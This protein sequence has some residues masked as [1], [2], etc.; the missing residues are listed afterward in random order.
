MTDSAADTQAD[1]G[2]YEEIVACLSLE[3][4][5]SFFLY[6]GAGSGK[7]RLLVDALDHIGAIYSRRLELR[8]QK[9]GVITYTNAACDEILS[10]RNIGSSPL[11][12]VSTIHS[13]AWDLVRP[14]APD[15]R[16]WLRTDLAK[17]IEELQ[18]EEA[19]G[20]AGTQASITRNA[21]ISASHARLGYL[22][23]IKKF[24]YNPTGGNRERE[25]LNHSEVIE[26]CADLLKKPLMQSILVNRYPILLIDESQDTHGLLIDSL[27]GVEANHRGSWCF[28]LI[29][30]TMQRIYGDG[31]AGIE[32]VLPDVWAR[33]RKLLNY[34][35]PKRIVRLL[36]Q[37]RSEVDDHVQQAPENGTEGC[38]RLFL[39]SAASAPDREEVE[40]KARSH[41]S[42]VSEDA[43]WV[44]RDSCK[45][46]TLEHHMAASRLG[47]EEVFKPLY[48]VDSFRTGLLDGTLPAV[49]FF[50]RDILPLVVAQEEGDEF[51]TARI[52]REA[53]P[54][55]SR[56]TLATAADPPEQ[57]KDAKDAVTGLMALWGEQEPSCGEILENVATSSLLLI[58]DS[59]KP[60]LKLREAGLPSDDA[61]EGQ[62]EPLRDTVLA[63]KTFLNAP[64]S[65][66]RSYALYVSDL[67]PFGTHQ[68]V[69][70]LEFDRVMVIMDDSEARGF[71]FDYEKL[72]G[73]KERSA[74]DLKN[75][76]EGKETSLD[77]TRRL[78]YVTC[79]RAQKSLAMVVY[80][81]EPTRIQAKVLQS[82]WF[83]EDEIVLA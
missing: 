52:V 33:P 77:R 1:N 43:E 10:R 69:K 60:L 26:I 22:D 76:T 37:V 71:M 56:E 79:S 3:A 70:G 29:G 47:F 61:E 16:E 44:N 81:A 7:T 57:L 83:E 41:M 54:L 15:I 23:E 55:L 17:R 62:Q 75:E 28:G 13:F 48:A 12:H 65:Q 50:T 74:T 49:R 31:K 66:I 19:K 32:Q 27:M 39:V 72:L 63:L 8:G 11:F 82:E 45:I 78:F 35:C 18:Q 30:D 4:P 46:L 38:V 53:S 36:N 68:G 51:K 21:K 25:S 80:S 59:L 58:P 6:A 2:A 34:R 64:F 40:E 5:R 14:F 73:A 24:S 67:A 42:T 9:V 20:R